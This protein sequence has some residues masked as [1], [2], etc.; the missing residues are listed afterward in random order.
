VGLKESEMRSD[1]GI[2]RH[3]SGRIKESKHN[4]N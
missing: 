4:K 2:S 3:S 1:Y